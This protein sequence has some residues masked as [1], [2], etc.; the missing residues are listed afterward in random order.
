MKAP[1]LSDVVKR[2]LR[3]APARQLPTLAP[4][5]FRQWAARNAVPVVEG[6][7]RADVILW[8]D[9]FNNH[10]HPRIAQSAY[11]V[12]KSAGY[13]AAIPGRALCCGRP[14]YDVGMLDRAKGYL[15]SIMDH[16]GDSIEAGTPLVVLEPSCASVFRDELR[17]LFPTDPRARRL[18]AQTV[19]LSEF[20][21]SG[22]L[23]YEPPRVARRVL[24][25]GHCHQK[26]LMKMD[27]AQALLRKMGVTVE[28]PDSG[29]CGMAGAF[30]FEA[31][32]FAIS[33]AIGERVL[34]PAVRAAS[35]GTLIVADGFSC[36]EQIRQAT[37]RRA[38]HL[39]ELLSNH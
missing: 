26:A 39:A 28:M 30:G 31:D 8:V 20:L 15:Q 5:T 38:L 21:Q 10:F 14:L 18:S 4:I 17:N 13:S 12:L 6:P 7:D 33:Q 22:P 19:L 35:P 34:L 32:T 2:A 11:E 23:M 29:C 27:H 9:T 37:G 1:G 36:R 25:H 16:L 3:I 24:L